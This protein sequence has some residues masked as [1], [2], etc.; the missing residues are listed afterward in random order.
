MSQV[1]LDRV[2]TRTD[3]RLSIIDTDFHPMPY[4]TDAQVWRHIPAKWQ[5]YVETFGLRG[6]LGGGNSPAQRQFTHRLD[7]LDVDGRVGLNPDLA[8][9]HV[10]DRFDLSGAI[11]TCTHPNVVGGGVGLP[12][13]LDMLI[14]SASNDAMAHTWMT[15]DDRYF[16]SISVPRDH[17]HIVDEIRRCKESEFGDRYVQAYM[18]PAGQEPMGRP[19]Y[20][21][22]FEACEAYGIPI[23]FHVPGMGTTGTACGNADFY[24]EVHSSFGILPLSMVPSLIFEGVFDRFPNLK[25]SLLELGWSWA[26]P[27]SWRL[28][29]AWSKLRDE[30]PNLQRKPSEYLRDHFWYSTQPFEEPERAEET[31]PLF[32]MFEEMGFGERLMYSSDY[33]HWDTD[34][35]MDAVPESFPTER[36]RRILGQN[37]SALYG[38]PLKA[39]TGIPVHG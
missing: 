18:S 22:I 24:A 29:S 30:I 13:E 23:A 8:R 20:W 9:E 1:T 6:G 19:R 35:P 14:F 25:V 11:L 28:D 37:A 7:A 21:P 34:W 26:I 12:P 31:E 3:E 27:L 36:R 32:Q 16:A 5:R 33:P 38:I 17:P 2:E 4:P 39:N 15:T 10:L